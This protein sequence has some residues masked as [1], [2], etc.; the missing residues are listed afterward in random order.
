MNNL[1]LLCVH[2]CVYDGI[3]ASNRGGENINA[4]ND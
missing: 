1:G 2:I 4:E 3:A